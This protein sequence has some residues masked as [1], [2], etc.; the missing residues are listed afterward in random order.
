DTIIFTASTVAGATYSWT[1]PNGFTSSLQNPTITSGI[2]NNAGTYT[3]VVDNG[4]ASVPVTTN[5]TINTTP[6]TPTTN[7]NTPLC[8][9]STLNLTSASVSGA[10]Y[11][12]TGPVSFSST[13]QNPSIS[14][15]ALNQAGTYSV[16][17]TA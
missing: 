9:G 11:S 2:A 1:G 12:W 14:S 8:V 6:A 5:V 16:I 15:I 17:A 13:L 10:S 7:G 3:L 4:C